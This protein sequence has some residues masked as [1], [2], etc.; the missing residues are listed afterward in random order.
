MAGHSA[1]G[2]GSV[3]VQPHDDATKRVGVVDA[4]LLNGNTWDFA[5]I[6]TDTGISVDNQIWRGSGNFFTITSKTIDQQQQVG[7]LLRKVGAATGQTI[8]DLVSN[9]PNSNYNRASNYSEA[10]DSG[11]P[12]FR[13]TGNNS[14]LYG[15]SY[16][17]ILFSGGIQALYFPW[18]YIRDQI[19]ANPP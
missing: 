6:K 16:K 14:D 17:R 12:V 15:M 8:G 1:D 2:V 7:T 18:D 13:G 5:F 3:I 10:G 9:S 4:R 11:A 19:G